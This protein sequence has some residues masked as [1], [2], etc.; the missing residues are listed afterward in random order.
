MDQSEKS[1]FRPSSIAR[2]INCNL[3]RWLPLEEKTPEELF[4][5]Q[6]RSNDHKRLEEERFTEK[7]L[8]CKD[9]FEKIKSSCTFF[10]KEAYLQMSID[11]EFLEGTPDVYGYNE[12]TKTL[13]IIDYKTGRSYVIAENNEQLL[14]YALLIMEYHTDWNIERIELAILN[15]QHDAVNR[16]VYTS[17]L[18]TDRL[19]KQ[20]IE[21]REKNSQDFS[22]GRPGKWC[23]F[24]P[25]KRYCIRQKSYK[26]LKKYADIDTDELIYTIK[27]RR[28]EI[29]A[30]EKDVK[31]GSYSKLLSPLLV[32]R[33]KRSWKKNL[34]ETFYRMNPM[35]ISQAEKAFSKEM[36]DAYTEEKRYKI[37]Q[38]H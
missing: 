27:T 20:I 36:I 10:F 25:A 23:T 7:E 16:Y 21:A 4:Y 38:F 3:W 14:A 18:Y 5:L 6:E 30:R 15:T 2:Y 1:V 11:E 33:I 34:P 12:E 28:Q 9:Y 37:L 22:F 17:K 29:T 35:T 31:D 13:H 26:K 8:R 19:K 32:E 24:C